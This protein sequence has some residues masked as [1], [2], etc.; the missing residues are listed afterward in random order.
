VFGGRGGRG[1]RGRCLWRVWLFQTSRCGECWGHGDAW[2]AAEPTTG[3][4]RLV[5]TMQRCKDAQRDKKGRRGIYVVFQQIPSPERESPW[6]RCTAESAH[7][8]HLDM[9][10]LALFDTHGSSG[11]RQSAPRAAG[12]PRVKFNCKLHHL[13]TCLPP[14]HLSAHCTTP[15]IPPSRPSTLH[16]PPPSCRKHTPSP[17]TR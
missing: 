4:S 5:M 3:I 10:T 1:R 8:L 2:A 14:V 16:I 6:R 7:R 17:M 15:Q 11:Y 13:P 9:V 12:P